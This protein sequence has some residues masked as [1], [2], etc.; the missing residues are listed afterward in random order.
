MNIVFV[1]ETGVPYLN[2]AADT[3]LLF[4]ANM[5]AQNN[6]IYI[7]NRMPYK[8][9][10]FTV[11]SMLDENIKVVNLFSSSY[12]LQKI[13]YRVL[14]SLISYPVELIYLLRLNYKININVLHIYSGHFAD[15]LFY[16]IISKIISA[17]TCLQ[18]VEFRFSPSAKGYNKI[19]GYLVDYKS[20]V[21][22]NGFIPISTYISNHIKS[23]T[24][25]KPIINIPPICNFDYISSISNDY[26]HEKPYLLYCGFSGYETVIFKIIDCFE[27][28]MN[29]DTLSLDADLIL[30]VN[31]D[32]KN[33][34]LKVRNNKRIKILQNIDFI[35]LIK[36]YKSAEVLFIPLQNTIREIARFPNKICEYTASKGLILT[37]NVGEIPLYFTD[38]ENAVIAKDCSAESLLEQLIWIFQNPDKLPA[39]RENAYKLGC[40]FFDAYKYEKE[41]NSFLLKL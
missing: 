4:L 40:D 25:Q 34:K 18:Y 28:L 30:I 41:I 11:D 33:L 17:K 5:L 36:L 32:I 21:F 20:Y 9:I 1:G 26:N 23:L 37:T 12:K 29:H 19:N 10:N 3:R 8:K 24:P 6:K 15:H 39:I 13:I 38:K 16:F 7:L 35:D 2:R 31:G 27:L 22:F 14:F